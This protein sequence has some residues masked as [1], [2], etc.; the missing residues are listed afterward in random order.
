M[1]KIRF[2]PVKAKEEEEEEEEE[3]EVGCGEC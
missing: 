1:K 2:L 3:E